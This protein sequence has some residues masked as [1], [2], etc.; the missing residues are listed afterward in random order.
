MTRW[1]KELV[2]DFR[3]GTGLASDWIFGGSILE[4]DPDSEESYYYAESGPLLCVS[5]FATATID[6]NVP[7]TASDEGLLYEAFS[8]NLPAKGTKVYIRLMPGE[9][10]DAK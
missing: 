5:N 9:F 10:F 6:L 8:E 4:E 2:R 3:F 1:G 7:S